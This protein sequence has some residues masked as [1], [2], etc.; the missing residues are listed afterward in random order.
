MV[1][2]LAADLLSIPI[3]KA[4][5]A[6]EQYSVVVVVIVSVPIKS[7]TLM[8]IV[9]ELE[10]PF[11][12]VTVTPIVSPSRRVRVTLAVRREFPDTAADGTG[13]EAM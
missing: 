8:V 3:I 6:P 4:I 7:L 9:A 1:P 13:T 10:H 11:A 2:P 5:S 12:L